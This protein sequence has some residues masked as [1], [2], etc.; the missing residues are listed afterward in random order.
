MKKYQKQFMLFSI[1]LSLSFLLSISLVFAV[2]EK[3][4][5]VFLPELPKKKQEAF[6]K[7]FFKNGNFQNGEKLSSTSICDPF[8][9]EVTMEEVDNLKD[10]CQSTKVVEVPTVAFHKSAVNMDLI[11]DFPSDLYNY[12]VRPSGKGHNVLFPVHPLNTSEKVA[13]QKRLT[14]RYQMGKPVMTMPMRHL[15]SRSKVCVPKEIVPFGVKLGTNHV[16]EDN[17]NPK[18]AE[19]KL[20]GEYGRARTNY[21]EKVDTLIGKEKDCQFLKELGYI[22]LQKTGEG[23]L[24]RDLTPLQDGNIYLPL[25]SIPFVGRELAKYKKED[26]KEFWSKAFAEAMGRCKA[27]HLLRYGFQMITPNAQNMLL[28]F[29]TDLNPKE[30]IYRDNSDT[31]F[32]NLVADVISPIID[33]NL[34]V[35]E[36]GYTKDKKWGNHID[37]VVHPYSSTTTLFMDEGSK[38]VRISD[39]VMDEWNKRQIVAYL[40]TINKELGVNIVPYKSENNPAVKEY[41]TTYKKT[42]RGRE[43]ETPDS[44]DLLYASAIQNFLESDIGKQKVE[45]YY[46]NLIEKHKKQGKEKEKRKGVKRKYG[47]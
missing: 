10:Y 38:K 6:K 20:D 42:N 5:I 9:M 43:R 24:I 32:V 2:T 22:S 37:H 28:R 16:S 14:K 27:M 25:L 18:K 46:K 33:T 39:D 15:A 19:M 34:G 3:P 1:T 40:D 31:L 13:G 29:D 23:Y 45:E 4:D 7:I 44:G 30:I 12:L 26:F 11:P 8:E 21:M 17:Y 41:I 35:L 36:G 47:I